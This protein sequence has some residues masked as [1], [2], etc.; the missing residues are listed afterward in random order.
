[1]LASMQLRTRLRLGVYWDVHGFE[2]KCAILEMR[3][4]VEG[5]WK[6]LAVLDADTHEPILDPVEAIPLDTE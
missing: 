1:M 5:E 2:R 4:P 6:R 3:G